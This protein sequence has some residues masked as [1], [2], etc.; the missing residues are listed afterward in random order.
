MLSGPVRRAAP[1]SPALAATPAFTRVGAH[2]RFTLHGE[3]VEALHEAGLWL[4][5]QRAL[6]VSDLH[7]EKGSWFAAAGQ[8]LPPYDTAATLSRLEALCARLEPAIVVSLGDSFHDGAAV[9]RMAR[10]DLSRLKALTRMAR[11]VWIQG[12][13]DPHTPDEVAGERAESVRIGRLTLRHEPTAGDAPGEVAGHLHPCARVG[14][15]PRSV[16]ARCFATDGARLVMPAFGAYTG[17]LNLRDPAFT[18][19]FARGAVALAIGRAQV[20]PIGPDRQV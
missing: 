12:N 13:H 11:F 15:S 17:G 3:Q 6:I 10:D 9:S 18:P 5:E 19:L 8:L 14:G 16:R 20:H 2:V 7:L 1:Q 4:V